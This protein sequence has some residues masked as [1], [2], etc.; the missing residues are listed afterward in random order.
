MVSRP[1]QQGQ[2][3]I[4]VAMAP[5]LPENRRRGAAVGGEVFLR[6]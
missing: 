1:L 6:P 3:T 2:V 5:T 4:K